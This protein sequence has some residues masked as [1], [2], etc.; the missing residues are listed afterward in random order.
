[1]SKTR[2]AGLVAATLFATH[3]IQ[4]QSARAADDYPQ[5]PIT[6]LV[7]FGPGGVT[8]IVARL[9]APKLK[10]RLGQP[11]VVANKPGASGAVA[12]E[13]MLNA[14]ADGYT[15]WACTSSLTVI[16]RLFKDVKFNAARDIVPV[17]QVASVPYLLVAHPSVQAD[18]LKQLVELSRKKPGELSYGSPGVGTMSHLAAEMWYADEKIRLRHVPYKGSLPVITDLLGGHIN[19]TFDQEAAVAAHLASG[20]LKALG[21]AGGERS[22]T[23]PN[24]PTF[25]EQ[26]VPFKAEA[27]TGICMKSGTPKAIVDKVSAA[28]RYAMAEPDVRQRYEQLGMSPRATTPEEFQRQFASDAQRM[29]KVIT[30]LGIE[31]Q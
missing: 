19:L 2:L 1:M 28:A 22:P 6:F 4:P 30:D 21:I 5:R 29:G 9:I 16:N 10:D 20:K 17:A 31:A 25:A 14:P 3:L 7:G 23:L 18:T 27:W 13:Q 26:G 15:M 11:V 24:V 12:A 8:D